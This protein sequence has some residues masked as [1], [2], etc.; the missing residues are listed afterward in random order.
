MKC[1]YWILEFFHCIG[2]SSVQRDDLNPPALWM[3]CR[4]PTICPVH[5]YNHGPFITIPKSAGAAMIYNALSHT[6]ILSDYL[7]HT[8][9]EACQINHFCYI[10]DPARFGDFQICYLLKIPWHHFNVSLSQCHVGARFKIQFCRPFVKCWPSQ[11]LSSGHVQTLV[12]TS[13][14]RQSRINDSLFGKLRW[15]GSSGNIGRI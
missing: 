11:G 13:A 12:P 15:A 9:S 5:T 4:C 1:G 3:L 10:Y 6:S 8:G 7:F 2:Y 14:T